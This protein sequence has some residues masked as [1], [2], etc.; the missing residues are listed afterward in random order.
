LETAV[1]LVWAFVAV[2]R[3]SRQLVKALARSFYFYYLI[4]NIL[5]ASGV[6]M[7]GYVS[8]GAAAFQANVTWHSSFTLY[9]VWNAAFYLT[10]SIYSILSVSQD[11]L[12]FASFRVRVVVLVML[13]LML[14]GALV[15]DRMTPF[16]EIALDLGIYSTTARH[17]RNSAALNLIT[18]YTKMIYTLSRNPLSSVILSTAY[19]VHVAVWRKPP[20]SSCCWSRRPTAGCSPVLFGPQMRPRT[21]LPA[22][23]LAA[24]FPES[25]V[26]PPRRVSALSQRQRQPQAA[27]RLL[28]RRLSWLGRWTPTTRC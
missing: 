4:A 1:L 8:E 17:L 3:A 21:A 22:R 27:C 15:W 7:F 11:A 12:A 10:A 20:P 19:E 13:D 9:C 28:S 23:P 25:A 14:V 26:Q 18:L 6:S 16:N 5:V 24:L 2:A